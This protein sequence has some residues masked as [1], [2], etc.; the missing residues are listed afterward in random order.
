MSDETT[1]DRKL[2]VQPKFSYPSNQSKRSEKMQVYFPYLFDEVSI[3]DLEHAVTGRLSPFCGSVL[4][5]VDMT[6]ATNEKSGRSFKRAVVH[7]TSF[8]LDAFYESDFYRYTQCEIHNFAYLRQNIVRFIRYRKTE[9]SYKPQEKPEGRDVPDDVPPQPAPLKRQVALPISS[10]WRD[11]IVGSPMES[12][13]NPLKE[14]FPPL[15]SDT[16]PFDI[17]GRHEVFGNLIYG[18]VS[19]YIQM[20][21]SVPMT[22]EKFQAMAGKIT[23]MMLELNEEGFKTC[24]TDMDEFAARFQEAVDIYKKL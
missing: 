23:G 6:S 18:L 9:N 16:S 11:L 24:V 20:M 10:E 5:K 21:P 2:I 12:S 14:E 1:F 3:A 13:D 19:A 15:A 7:F 8:R 22:P 17:R 4:S